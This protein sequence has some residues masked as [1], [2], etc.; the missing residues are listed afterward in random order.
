MK[1]LVLFLAFFVLS[2]IAHGSTK[3][4][5]IPIDRRQENAKKLEAFALR[6]AALQKLKLATGSSVE[7]RFADNGVPTFLKGRLTG[8]APG[9]KVQFALDFTEQYKDLFLLK[10]PKSELKLKSVKEDKAGNTH[11][12]FEQTYQGLPVWGAQLLVHFSRDGYIKSVN[13]RW[14]LTPAIEVQPAITVEDALKIAQDDL[15]AEKFI[16]DPTSELLVFPWESQTYL[17]WQITLIPTLS[18]NW[19]YF[20][21]AKT[22]KILLKYNDVKNDGPVVASG[23]DLMNN[24]VPLGAYV[25]QDTAI[26]VDATKPMFVPPIE[27]YAG[28]IAT[29]D[30]KND[31]ILSN[32][33]FVFD[34]NGD[35]VF[36]DNVG[37]KASVS[38]HY[39]IGLTFDYFG[40]NFGRNSWDDNGGSLFS[41]VHYDTDFNNAFWNGSAMVFG[42]GDGITFSPL[43]GSLDVAAHE[44][45]HAITDATANLIY[46]GEWG[47][48]NEHISDVWGAMLD[49]GDWLIGE[50]VYT[51]GSPGD[52]LRNMADPNNPGNPMDAQ[53]AHMSEYRYLPSSSDPLFDN[54]G[55]HINS[56][57]PNKACYL[58]AS[59]IQRDTTE[60]LYYQALVFYLFPTSRF[61]D[62]RRAL[63]SAADDLYSLEP[64]YAHIVSSIENSFDAV[65]VYDFY[66]LG[67][68]VLAYDDG[69][70]FYYNYIGPVGPPYNLRWAVRFTP[71]APCSLKAVTAQFLTTGSNGVLHIWNDSLGSGIP[72]TELVNLGFNRTEILPTWQTIDLSAYNLFFENDFYVGFS[73]TSV[74]SFLLMDALQDSNHFTVYLDTFSVGN[75]LLIDPNHVF[76]TGDPLIRANVEYAVATDVGDDDK[77]LRPTSFALSQNYPNPFNP[78]TTIRFSLA[79]RGKIDLEIYNLLGERIRVLADQEFTA[80]EHSLVWDGRDAKGKIVS[81]G[82]YFYRL[83]GEDY[84]ETKKMIFIK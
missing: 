18:K 54:G 16:K 29:L 33:V 59:A 1:G 22:G 80:G 78:T 75:W 83:K 34:P 15:K 55:V 42:D 2:S 28:V 13:G 68:D 60:Q 14:E 37:L 6:D 39:N 45:A 35:T 49:T 79:K 3:G 67:T 31:T 66:Q 77:V 53:P 32:A 27:N 62:L 48:L 11:I 4:K 20:V 82:V 24:S 26:L 57:I 56:G 72:G 5:P 69:S 47:A 23:I 84:S 30:M 40:N 70:A 44:L 65:G 52:A 41:F 63:L 61:V 50:D 19:K 36:N 73:A 38:A 21:D 58:L 10:D 43:S 71:H 12:R 74:D 25:Y 46:L 64:N 76:T 7:V 8:N 9:D 81:S 17:A 51:P